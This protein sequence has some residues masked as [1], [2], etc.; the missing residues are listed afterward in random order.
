MPF[1][2]NKQACEDAGLIVHPILAQHVT[3]DGRTSMEIADQVAQHLSGQM[4]R[5]SAELEVLVEDE[6]QQPITY[7]HHYIDDV[8][9]VPPGDS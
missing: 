7:N 9:R 6:R 8:Q 3:Q 5:A 4:S 1:M 2:L